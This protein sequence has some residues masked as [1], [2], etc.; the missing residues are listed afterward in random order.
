MADKKMFVRAGQDERENN[1]KYGLS[2]VFK[3]CV[4][5]NSGGRDIY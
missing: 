4:R 3:G 2:E 5:P 1:K